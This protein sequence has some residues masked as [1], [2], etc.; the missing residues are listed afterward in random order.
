MISQRLAKP[1]AGGRLP[2]VEIM[3]AT[4]TVR[5]L[6]GE[7]RTEKLPQADR[8]SG[9]GYAAVRLKHLAELYNSQQISGT[10]ALRLASNPEAVVLPQCGTFTPGVNVRRD[11][12]GLTPDTLL[13]TSARVHC[14]S[15]RSAATSR[16]DDARSVCR[17]VGP[18]QTTCPSASETTH[19]F[20]SRTPQRTVPP[21][22]ARSTETARWLLC[23]FVHVF[24][25]STTIRPRQRPGRQMS[26]VALDE[27][28]NHP[29]EPEEHRG[30]QPRRETPPVT[31]SVF[32]NST[33]RS[34]SRHLVN[35]TGGHRRGRPDDRPV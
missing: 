33:M 11:W 5:K 30:G 32:I 9:R 31:G 7:G 35:R 25:C 10:E 20:P 19:F 2:V 28:R 8:Q 27:L 4:P 24:A 12:V 23:S 34:S 15:I 14:R 26:A 6:I 22:A 13:P 29:R 21:R 1:R 16:I 3:W 18:Q 17:Q